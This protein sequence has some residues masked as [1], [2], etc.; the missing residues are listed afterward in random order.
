MYTY[1]SGAGKDTNPCTLAAPCRTLQAALN[2]T[3]PDGQIESL[4]SADYGYA[5]ITRGVTIIGRRGRTGVLA[6]NV[7]GIAINAGPTDVV[8][9]RGLDIDGTGTGANGILFASGAELNVSE[10]VIYGFTT[11]IDISSTNPNT[12]SIANSLIANSSIAISVHSSATSAGVLSD[13][14]VAGNST[15]VSATGASPWNPVTLNIARSLVVNNTAVG[16]LSNGFSV[17]SVV[18]TMIALNGVG[19]EAQNSTAILQL[20]NSFVSGNGTGWTALNGGHVYS[21]G[22]N[23]IGGDINGDSAPPRPPPPVYLT[24]QAGGQFLDSN[25]GRLIA[26]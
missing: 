26:Q 22:N 7:S 9:L 24:D 20:S 16:I 25:G 2:Q 17:I 12:F 13:L 4:N 21:F 3:A 8:N 11:G 14:N 5:T 10:S 1:I 18:D 15:G 19:V 6:R 23:A